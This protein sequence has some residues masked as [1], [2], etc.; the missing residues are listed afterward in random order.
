MA[1]PIVPITALSRRCKTGVEPRH[2][3]WLAA[4]AVV[5]AIIVL[6]AMFVRTLRTS[7]FVDFE[8]YYAGASSLRQGDPLYAR[9]AAYREAEYSL[10]QPGTVPPVAGMPYVYPPAFAI[11]LIP[12][13]LLPLE[14]ATFIWFSIIFGCLIGAAY[15]LTGLVYP[16]QRI[17]ALAVV[18]GLSTLLALYQPAR[19]DLVTGQV[20]LPLFLLV[21]LSLS[22]FVRR[23]HAW[24][25]TWLALAVVV[26]PTLGFLILFLVWK[27]AYRAASVACALVATVYAASA[28]ILGTS[29]FWDFAAVASYW[30]RSPWATAPINQ[31]PYGMLLRLLTVNPYTVPIADA[32]VLASALR[33]TIVGLTLVTVAASVGRSQELPARRLTLEFGLA[34]VAM[35]LVAPLAQDIYY[36]HL[37]IPLLMI[38]AAAAER[39]TPRPMPVVLVLC[40]LAL[41]LYFCLPSLRLVSHAFYWFYDTPLSGPEL[42]LTGAH[43]YGLIAVA[44]LTFVAVHWYRRNVPESQTNGHERVGSSRRAAAPFRAAQGASLK[45]TTGAASS[46]G[47]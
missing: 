30:S 25:G 17:H 9:A 41:Y 2:M 8:A 46:P 6:G 19:A 45:R 35:L 42:L 38:P 39:W 32:P 34:I 13:S 36:I 12:L 14:T 1:A 7:P 22:A 10:D 15:V 20:E 40:S 21:T 43:T 23:R 5:V 3:S 24:A 4:G 33:W 31:S 47:A 44:V 18:L 37:A 11:V 26:K 29:V 28:L 16:G 27:R